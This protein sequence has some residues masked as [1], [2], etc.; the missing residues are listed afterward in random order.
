MLTTSALEQRVRRALKHQGTALCRTRGEQQ[1]MYL[2]EYYVIDIQRNIIMQH[3]CGLE[4]LARELAA[5]T[6]A[7]PIAKTAVISTV[8]MLKRI[9]PL[10][11]L[12]LGGLV[13]EVFVPYGSCD[14]YLCLAFEMHGGRGFEQRLKENMIN[15][16]IWKLRKMGCELRLAPEVHSGHLEALGR[17]TGLFG[18]GETLE[19]GSD[20]I[21][22]LIFKHIE[23]RGMDRAEIE[24][25]I[26]RSGCAVIACERCNQEL[27]D[28]NGYMPFHQP[29]HGGG[30]G[31]A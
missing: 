2:G 17:Q 1:A 14:E 7:N 18:E 24:L 16:P 31:L 6:P 12:Q 11:P 3:H 9:F 19:E 30:R 5:S 25:R 15:M 4:A 8:K 13:V 23:L 10:S 22:S 26:K 29:C 20:E 28:I 21:L 27:P